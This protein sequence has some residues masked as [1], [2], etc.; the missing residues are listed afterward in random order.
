MQP[1]CRK[2]LRLFKEKIDAQAIMPNGLYPVWPT[3]T[4]DV[5]VRDLYQT[6]GQEPRL[7]KLLSQRTVVRTIEDAVKRG[8]LAL[9]L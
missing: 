7:P 1:C 2:E 4:P 9:T 3:G 8:V 5:E 6:F